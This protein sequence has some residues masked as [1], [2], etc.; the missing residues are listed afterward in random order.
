MIND[1]IKSITAQFIPTLLYTPYY[2]I[3]LLIQ[4]SFE[5]EHDEKIDRNLT[6]FQLIKVFIEKRGILALWSGYI[7]NLISNISVQISNTLITWYFQLDKFESGESVFKRYLLFLIA[8]SFKTILSWLLGFWCYYGYI[9]KCTDFNIKSNDGKEN[10]KKNK[11][12]SINYKKKFTSFEDLINKLKVNLNL[13]ICLFL[14]NLIQTLLFLTIEFSFDWIYL[15]I[16]PKSIHPRLQSIILR[17]LITFTCTFFVWPFQ[18]LTKCLT[19]GNRYYT[20]N[21]KLSSR[22][23]F[24]KLWKDARKHLYNGYFFGFMS[25]FVSVLCSVVVALLAIQKNAKA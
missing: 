1:I 24:Q 11:R 5:L 13:I 16:I 15:K 9:W 10:E 7:F 23:I 12:K 8:I 6:K 4:T 20:T 3:L 19:V 18:T 14:L 22:Q 2:T 25:Q 17:S 21:Y